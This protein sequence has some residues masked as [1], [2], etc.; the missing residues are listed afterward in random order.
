MVLYCRNFC[1]CTGI[2]Y[3]ITHSLPC[4]DGVR[5]SYNIWFL[6]RTFGQ[7]GT[8]SNAPARL[9]IR[10]FISSWWIFIM[11]ILW[12]Y[13]GTLTSFMTY[14]G[15]R[16]AVDTIEKLRHALD[17]HHI[18][19]G[20]TTGTTY[21]HFLMTNMAEVDP[22][23]ATSILENPDLQVHNVAE[24]MDLV[25]KQKYAFVYM[26]MVLRCWNRNSEVSP[27]KRSFDHI[28]SR[29]EETGLF[30]KWYDDV[31][32]KAKADAPDV[33]VN[34]VRALAMDD[35]QGAFYFLGIVEGVGLIVFLVERFVSRFQ[36]RRQTYVKSKPRRT[37]NT[38]Q[39]LLYWNANVGRHDWNPDLIRRR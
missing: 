35:L 39:E 15:R 2:L 19:Y 10:L 23:F 1:I 16:P 22:V 26:T 25:L 14:P 33:S 6:F 30:I 21:E 18:R 11:V 36:I 7:Q 32:F 20:T 8:P 28:V 13:A 27:C 34:T 29:L 3:I 17:H 4:K 37:H 5:R 31:F 38:K 24:G 9:S 12:C